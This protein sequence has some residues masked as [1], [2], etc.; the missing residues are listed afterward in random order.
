MET[1]QYEYI[2]IKEPFNIHTFLK[3]LRIRLFENPMQFVWNM[4]FYHA[5]ILF[6]TLALGQ[7]VPAKVVLRFGMGDIAAVEAE[8]HAINSLQA[9]VTNWMFLGVILFL[10]F[11]LLIIIKSELN[12]M[13]KQGKQVPQ[14]TYGKIMILEVVISLAG[15]FN[16]YIRT[17][18]FF[19]SANTLQ[20][21]IAYKWFIKKWKFFQYFF[22][23][24]SY[25]LIFKLLF[26]VAVLVIWGELKFIFT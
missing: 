14:L 17:G 3:N 20:V 10:D 22:I 21:A 23:A 4:M 11:A 8:M 2:R 25:I 12:L 9:I 5:E 13:N 26:Y 16:P 24:G 18:L 6:F 1:I 15:F 7:E 19:F